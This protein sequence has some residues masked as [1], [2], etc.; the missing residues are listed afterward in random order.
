MKKHFKVL[1]LVLIFCIVLSTSVK[2]YS[3]TFFA[4]FESSDIIVDVAYR[5]KIND[6]SLF[7]EDKWFDIM[8]SVYPAL[9]NTFVAS[10]GELIDSDKVARVAIKYILYVIFIS[11]LYFLGYYL[12]GKRLIAAM[13]AL[14]SAYGHKAI[15]GVFWGLHVGQIESQDVVTFLIPGLFLLFLK[16]KD[17]FKKMFLLFFVLGVLINFHAISAGFLGMAFLLTYFLS[18]ISFKR[19][20]ECVYFG[21]ALLVGGLPYLWSYFS[22]AAGGS[23]SVDL[24]LYRM[25]YVF[26]HSILESVLFMGLALVLGF[27]GYYFC[28]KKENDKVLFW[29]FVSVML[30]SVL[31]IIASYFFVDIAL[32]QFHRASRLVFIPL[33][34]F[35][36][37]F[38]FYLFK[39]KVFVTSAVL[40]CLLVFPVSIFAG[41]LV[42][43]DALESEDILYE[44]EL[45]GLVFVDASGEDYYELV[46]YAKENTF[47][48]DVFLVPPYGF[49][50]FRTLAE[51]A[52]VVSFKDGAQVIVSTSDHGL[53][54]YEEYQAVRRAYL[55]GDF[56]DVFG[57]D[58]IVVDKSK[59]SLDF[60]V[61][62]ENDR[63]VLY[64]TNS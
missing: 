26:N 15:N 31:G 6:P 62:F 14:M 56:S 46:E 27:L 13:F 23:V 18:G 4:E 25:P 54:W 49:V 12:S 3:G 19:F 47:V 20:W 51:R 42:S 8:F 9:F 43:F 29:F 11:S 22:S 7:T 61:V 41:T 53:E 44:R 50:S 21:V 48:D 64:K 10:A 38:I 33:L 34:Y 55:S 40:L 28:K 63:F 16:W 37:Y 32:F 17:D 60:S 2:I 35:S 57:A 52:I 59:N 30:I 58:Y 1:L 24:L 5:M 45:D 39:R 36:A